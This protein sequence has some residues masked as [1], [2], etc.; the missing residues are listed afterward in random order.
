MQQQLEI[1]GP[2]FNISGSYPS[3]NRVGTSE[4]MYDNRTTI[5][6]QRVKRKIE[7]PHKIVERKIQRITV[8][9]EKNTVSQFMIVVSTNWDI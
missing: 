6:I 5:L 4:T 9:K 7:N 8:F 2:V 3:V 1:K